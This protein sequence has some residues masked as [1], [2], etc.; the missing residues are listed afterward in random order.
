MKLKF[1]A[2]SS[3]STEFLKSRPN[4]WDLV[5]EIFTKESLEELDEMTEEDI[6]AVVEWVDEEIRRLKGASYSDILG[7]LSLMDKHEE[8]IAYDCIT[9]GLRLRNVGSEDFSWGDLLAIVRQSPRSSALF[10]AQ[11]PEEAVWGH[12]EQLL[13]LIADTLAAAN[14][15]RAQ[16]KK[17]DYPKPIPRP[18]VEG[19]KKFGNEAVS[20]DEMASWLGWEK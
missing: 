12:Q 15:Q 5:E 2:A 4:F 8:A 6:P 14:W 3:L 9:L 1:N 17:K 10:R 7:L 16:G 11:H 19:D 18:G 20:I 13:A